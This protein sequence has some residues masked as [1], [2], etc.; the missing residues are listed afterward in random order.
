VESSPLGNERGKQRRE[1]LNNQIFASGIELFGKK[2]AN[3]V[4]LGNITHNETTVTRNPQVL[5]LLNLP[6]TYRV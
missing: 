6:I 2:S 1:I 3:S 5:R 4:V